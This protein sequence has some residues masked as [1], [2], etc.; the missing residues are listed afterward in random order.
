MIMVT[1]NKQSTSKSTDFG[2]PPPAEPEP[3]CVV[4][5]TSAFH[6][7]T[8]TFRESAPEVGAGDR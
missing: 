5:K 6:T 4:D 3:G 7:G 8:K 2:V 1:L